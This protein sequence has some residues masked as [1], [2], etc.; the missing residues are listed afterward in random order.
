MRL[1]MQLQTKPRDRG[2][3]LILELKMYDAAGT[4]LLA[5]PLQRFIA[6]EELPPRVNH[7]QIVELRGVSFEAY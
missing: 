3:T 4:D 5:H 2:M 1:A 7:P 6:P